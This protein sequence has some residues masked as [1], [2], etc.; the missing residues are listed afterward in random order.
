MKTQ[1]TI[2]LHLFFYVSCS[3][4]SNMKAP[5]LIEPD[6]KIESIVKGDIIEVLSIDFTGDNK[7]E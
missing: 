3:G 6:E 7:R 2:L 1:I 4:Q 5:V